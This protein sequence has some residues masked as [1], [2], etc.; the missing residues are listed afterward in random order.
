MR[1][2][3]M[4]LFMLAVNFMLFSFQTAVNYV[5]SE[6]GVT[7]DTIYDNAGS[8]LSKADTGAGNY[9]V[10]DFD[11]SSVPESATSGVSGDTGGGFGD[12]FNTFKSWITGAANV[13]SFIIDFVNAVPNFIRGMGLPVELAYGLGAIWWF[14]GVFMVVSWLRWNI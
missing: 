7:P 4:L 1:I 8:P 2:T 3:V 11:G 13:G 14:M 10:K 6:Y 9:I 12:M 5:G